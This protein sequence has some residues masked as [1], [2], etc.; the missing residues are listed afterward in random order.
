MDI[1]TILNVCEYSLGI[2]EDNLSLH[3][4]A[5]KAGK[6]IGSSAQKTA[7]NLY[8]KT[9]K[10]SVGTATAKRTKNKQFSLLFFTLI[11]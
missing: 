1:S 3:L 2:N 5:K 9:A 6:H 7:A 8:K 11:V 10:Y 4:T